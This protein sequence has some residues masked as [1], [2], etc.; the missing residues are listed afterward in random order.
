MFS[1]TTYSIYVKDGTKGNN[2]SYLLLSTTS[3]T[4]DFLTQANTQGLNGYIWKGSYSFSGVAYNLYI[5]DSSKNNNFSYQLLSTSSSSTDFLTQANTHG[6]TGYIWKGSY[7]FLGVAYN[8]Y[9]KDS[10]KNNN[11]SYQLLSTSSSSTD[12]LTQANTHGSNGYIWKG[13]YSFL[14]VAYNLYIKDS[15]ISD[16]YS[17]HVLTSQSSSSDFLTQANTEGA[18]SYLYMNTY[19]FSKMQNVFFNSKNGIELL[20]SH[21]YSGL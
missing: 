18:D 7:S 12:F 17:Y 21:L 16:S 20:F 9:I 19:Y 2:F 6:S 13:S 14:G 10:S 3:T 1:G 5:K 8:L 15:S 4:S 11:F